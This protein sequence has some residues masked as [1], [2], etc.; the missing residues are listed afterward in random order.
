M[1]RVPA[2]YNE[3]MN[4]GSYEALAWSEAE[5]DY[6]W[7]KKLSPVTQKGEAKLLAA[8]KIP[9]DRA[10]LALKDALTGKPVL[11]HRSSVNWNAHRKAWIMIGNQQQAE[12]SNLG[13]VWYAE[14]PTP[15]GPWKKA[16]KVATHPRYSFYN[17]RHHVFFDE[18][19]GQVIYFEGTY[20][21][22]FSGNPVAVPRYDYNQL[23]YRLDLEDPR[24]GV[25][26]K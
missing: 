1:T 10:L 3:V 24:L 19:G 25:L 17:P 4:P 14:A 13:E 22:T 12:E 26:R 5:Q 21:E 23:M 6:V 16:V 8:G 15:S 2:S 20:S 18:K 9:A 11:I 7:Q